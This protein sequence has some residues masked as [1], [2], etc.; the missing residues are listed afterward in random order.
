MA[1][2]AIPVAAEPPLAHR[3]RAD[4]RIVTVNDLTN[5]LYLLRAYL[6]SAKLPKNVTIGKQKAAEVRMIYDETLAKLSAKL[7]STSPAVSL[8]TLGAFRATLK[9]T[10][11][12][13]FIALILMDDRLRDLFLKLMTELRN[14]PE[15]DARHAGLTHPIWTEML[16]AFN[17]ELNTLDGMSVCLSSCKFVA[18]VNVVLI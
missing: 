7:N 2:V 10:I 12:A 13:R 18:H 8:E 14:R 1:V 16:A 3:A 17:D 6:D 4:G 15:L 11:M 5:E 9:S